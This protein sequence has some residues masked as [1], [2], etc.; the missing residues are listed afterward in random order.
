MPAVHQF[1]DIDGVDP[2]LAEGR[3]SCV[4]VRSPRPEWAQEWVPA[5]VPP[6]VHRETFPSTNRRLTARSVE[7]LALARGR[8]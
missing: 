8:P 7:E 5:G 3:L 2:R 6:S 4:S 1:A